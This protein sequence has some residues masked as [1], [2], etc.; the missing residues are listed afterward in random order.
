MLST[1]EIATE[2]HIS[3]KHFIAKFL[4]V[5]CIEEY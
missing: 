5:K 2:V 3:M 4:L 1:L